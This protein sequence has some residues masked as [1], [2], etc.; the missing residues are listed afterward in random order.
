LEGISR[1]GFTEEFSSA[2]ADGVAKKGGE[3]IDGGCVVGDGLGGAE[4]AGTRRC[5]ELGSLPSTRRC[6]TTAWSACASATT[7]ASRSIAPC[8][9]SPTGQRRILLTLA[10]GTAKTM[11]A[12]QLVAKLRKSGWTA[13]RM[14]RVLYLA[15]RNLLVDQPKDDYFVR[16]FGNVVHK[17]SKGHAQRSREV[18]FALYQPLERGDEQALFSQYEKN[19]FDLIIIDECHRGSA[20]SSAQWRRTLAHFDEAV[21]IGLTRACPLTGAEY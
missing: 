5:G 6:A 19:Y 2:C 9:P 1:R 18:Y 11:V 17:I 7:S 21:Q 15:D 10:T 20:S 8:G 16:A 14:P 3:L 13:G 12:L 4:P